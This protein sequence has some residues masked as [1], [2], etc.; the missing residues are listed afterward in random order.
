LL[1]QTYYHDKSDEQNQTACLLSH[2]FNT[3]P[4][5]PKTKGKGGKGKSTEAT[6]DMDDNDDI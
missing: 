3:V 5:E 6:E 1:I 2:M 4:T